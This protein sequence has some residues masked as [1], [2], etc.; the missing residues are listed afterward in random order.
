[1]IAR[2]NSWFCLVLRF[3]LAGVYV[4]AGVMKL[5]GSSDALAAQIVRTQIVPFAWAEYLAAMLPFAELLIGA[6]L[7]IGWR[8]KGA[9]SAALVL[10][11]AF[12]LVVGQALAR[13]L[14]F[15]C[16]CFG[17][18]RSSLSPTLVFLRA[19]LLAAAAVW[20]RGCALCQAE[21]SPI[22]TRA[23]TALCAS[24]SDLFNESADPDR[25]NLRE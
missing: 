11:L 19:V 10:A 14:D 21:L 15:D 3:A 17:N 7:F 1:M 4:Y 18:T 24:R 13:G 12:T 23:L 2:V 5:G 22:E 8:Q 9:A 20:L 6:W 16:Q 25:G